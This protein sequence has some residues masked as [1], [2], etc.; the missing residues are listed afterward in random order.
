MSSY[1]HAKGKDNL[2]YDKP[3]SRKYIL[4]GAFFRLQK[5]LRW[6]CKTFTMG[7]VQVRSKTI[8]HF[9]SQWSSFYTGYDTW[10]LKDGEF[11]ENFRITI[12]VN[13]TP[14]INLNYKILFAGISNPCSS[15]SG[16]RKCLRNFCYN[17]HLSSK[18]EQL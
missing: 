16:L 1:K 6:R 15:L 8:D 18:R 14:H 17:W 9:G 10:K 11:S 13:D 2:H 3:R 5:K 12:I 7:I 4:L